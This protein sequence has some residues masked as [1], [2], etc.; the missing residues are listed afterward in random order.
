MLPQRPGQILAAAKSLASMHLNIWSQRPSAAEHC[1][2]R[3][4]AGGAQADQRP[5]MRKENG[6]PALPANVYT[7]LTRRRPR[8]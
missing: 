3:L 2:R 6:L 5:R 7:G 1:G 4:P 8:S